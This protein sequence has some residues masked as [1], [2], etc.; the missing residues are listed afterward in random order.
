MEVGMPKLV[1]ENIPGPW[2]TN[3]FKSVSL[4]S[5]SWEHAPSLIK[6]FV[7]FGH[8]NIDFDGS[9]TAYG[10]TGPR[11]KTARVQ[12][13]NPPPDDCFGNGA[14]A[15]DGYF[16]MRSMA[17]NDPLVVNGTVLIDQDAP[18]FLGKFPIVQQLQ[19][20]DPRPG[21]YVSKS[22]HRHGPLHLQNSYINS[23]EIAYG[24]LDAQFLHLGVAFGDYG[25]VLRH[26]QSLQSPFYYVDGG[27]GKF[28]LGECSHK[29]ATN[30]GVT[31]V[32]GTPCGWDN[33]FPVSFL[34][35]P[36]SGDMHYDAVAG[37]EIGFGI[38]E[39]SENSIMNALHPRLV[40]L[41]RAD[42]A[43][44]LPR[45]M[46]FNEG[47]PSVAPN[48]KERLDAFLK[49]RGVPPGNFVHIL[50]RLSKFGFWPFQDKPKEERDPFNASDKPRLPPQS[51]I[52]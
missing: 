13:V 19:N 20:G 36:R 5:V 2:H 37:E 10:P 50:T 48:G 33:N 52:F 14:N 32:A 18:K 1:F 44:D 49:K 7:F 31:R 9:P 42:N 24:A 43:L 47:P 11:P 25:L 22:S 41:S 6:A 34:V 35:F 46:A 40:E 45:L 3:D 30:L 16:G 17:P 29:V 12:P 21:Y 26:D 8:V 39:R 28:A 4:T 27:A 38:M 23:A 51:Q 15:A